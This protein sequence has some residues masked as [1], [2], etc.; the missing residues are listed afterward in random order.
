MDDYTQKVYRLGPLNHYCLLRI[1]SLLL[2]NKPNQMFDS[3]L[4]SY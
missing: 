2:N 3:A 1:S 4:D